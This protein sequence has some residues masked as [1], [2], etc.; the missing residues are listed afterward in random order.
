M[1][2]M[3]NLERWLNDEFRKAGLKCK[4]KYRTVLPSKFKLLADQPVGEIYDGIEFTDFYGLP[5]SI[6]IGDEQI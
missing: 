6:R 1:G 2:E 3:I 5:I 4:I